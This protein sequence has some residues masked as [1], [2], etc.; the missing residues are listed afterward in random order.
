MS[1]RCYA[2]R[3]DITYGGN[4]GIACSPTIF[5]EEVITNIWY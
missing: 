3:L 4:A 5:F 2:Q 1:R